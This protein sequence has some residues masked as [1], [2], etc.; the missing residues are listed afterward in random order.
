MPETRIISG[1]SAFELSK[2]GVHT[3]QQMSNKSGLSGKK[4]AKN[5]TKKLTKK[6]RKN[7]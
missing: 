5:I 3:V 2:T 4:I 1:L 7:D 6:T